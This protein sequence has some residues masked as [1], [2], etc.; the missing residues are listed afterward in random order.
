VSAPSDQLDPPFGHIVPNWPVPSNVGALITTR[1]GGVSCAPFDGFNLGA[2]VG[3]DP[4]HVAANRALLQRALPDAPAWLEQVHGTAIVDAGEGDE[5]PCADGAVASR[6]GIVCA[7]LTAD[8]L[9]VLLA[10]SLGTTV[11]VAHAGWR[12]LAAGV[13]EAALAAL[14]L[15]PE[16]VLAYLGPAISG[17]EYEVGR[18]VR[19]AFVDHMPAAAGGFTSRIGGKYLCNLYALARM[20]LAA[21]GVK[22]VYGGGYC[23]YRD[24]TRFFSYRREGRTGRMASLIW[25]R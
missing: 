2:H 8:C 15:P 23:V 18:E 5:R 19:E 3:D 24:T 4:S 13:I 10:D 16:R 17:A 25:M 22:Q 20:R 7:V 21:A 9:P 11:G 6:T 14:R 1:Q 12:G